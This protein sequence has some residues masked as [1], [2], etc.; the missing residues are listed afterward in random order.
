MKR[1]LTDIE[2]FESMHK[3]DFGLEFEETV[4]EIVEED[5]DL[6]QELGNKGE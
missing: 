4:T 3:A 5:K 6:L 2:A 1:E